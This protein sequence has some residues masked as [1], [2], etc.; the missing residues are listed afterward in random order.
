[1]LTRGSLDA[2]K[3]ELP[4]KQGAASDLALV[5][6]RRAPAGL[7]LRAGGGQRFIPGPLLEAAFE[8][9]RGCRCFA[10]SVPRDPYDLMNPP[11]VTASCGRPVEGG[12]ALAV[13][14]AALTDDVC[15]S[16]HKRAA[17]KTFTFPGSRRRTPAGAPRGPQFARF[18]RGNV[19]EMRLFRTA[20]RHVSGE[21][22]PWNVRGGK[23]PASRR[24]GNSNRNL[25]ALGCRMPSAA[26]CRWL[27]S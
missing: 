19:G 17:S 9:L 24:E 21:G 27:P 11:A 15:D 8:V 18:R 26:A 10:S 20:S 12:R 2:C 1:V 22:R 3:W 7:L 14:A 5:G 13:S 23:P 6:S 4:R 25:A 16:R